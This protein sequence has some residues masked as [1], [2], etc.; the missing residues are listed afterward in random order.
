MADNDEEIED[1]D[2]PIRNWKAI[3]PSIT[4]TGEGREIS[5][6]EFDCQ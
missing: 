1:G 3:N 6:D 4:E 2:L 5:G